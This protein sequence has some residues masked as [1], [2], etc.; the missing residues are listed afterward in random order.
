MNDDLMMET[1]SNILEDHNI[2]LPSELREKISKDLNKAFE[3]F[4]EWEYYSA[5]HHSETEEQ[6]QIKQLKKEME[7][8]EDKAQR[9]QEIIMSATNA[10][11]RNPEDADFILYQMHSMLDDIR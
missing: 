2:E 10:V 9:R 4:R 6:R 7:K 5:P 1:L 8:N 3:S 11:A